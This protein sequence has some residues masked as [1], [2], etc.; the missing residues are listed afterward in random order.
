M[1]AILQE[2]QRRLDPFAGTCRGMELE[3]ALAE[4]GIQKPD[5]LPFYVFVEL[6]REWGEQLY[7][8][9][10]YDLDRAQL[11]IAD[12]RKLYRRFAPGTFDAIFSSPTYGTRMA[13]HHDAQDR[14]PETGELTSRHTYT[15]TLGRKL[16]AGNSGAMQWGDAYRGLH[17]VVWDLCEWLLEPGGLFVLN[18]S[19]HVR[20]GE[21]VPVTAWH[22]ETLL[23]LGLKLVAHAIAVRTPR[24]RHGAN[25]EK[26]CPA[27]SVALF[28]KPTSPG[29]LPPREL[30]DRVETVRRLRIAEELEDT[31]V[32]Y[33]REDALPEFRAYEAQRERAREALAV[34]HKAGFLPADHDWCEQYR[35]NRSAWR[36][37][38]PP[39][40]MM[41]A[42]P[43]SDAQE[44]LECVNSAIG[45]SELERFEGDPNT[46]DQALHD[47]IQPWLE[48]G[49]A[50]ADF[51]APGGD[52]QTAAMLE[53]AQQLREVDPLG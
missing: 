31:A 14:D 34:A 20:G 39:K 25:H 22:L 27:E 47:L 3:A 23:G 35:D 32:R 28:W 48:P 2:T 6:E 49:L 33:A 29:A 36:K 15:H 41:L 18:V 44:I 40:R 5:P 8:Q 46:A 1:A 30:L 24:L 42:R 11:L 21:T 13:D 9:P 50:L 53:E 52:E 10:S 7:T 12:S 37:L 26:R 43:S 17:E 16:S 4:F 38:Q 51:V 19:D 45:T